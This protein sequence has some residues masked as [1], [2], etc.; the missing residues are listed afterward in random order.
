MSEVE[1]EV[2]GKK[3]VVRTDLRYTETEEWAKKEKDNRVREGITDYAQ[4]ELRDIVG[5]ELPEVGTEVK[6]GDSIGS[7]ESVKAVSD[8]YAAV[9]GRIV[10]VNERL[11]EEPELLNK[12]PYGDGWIVIIEMSDPNEYEQLLTPEAYIEKHK[13]SK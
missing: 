11:L 4:K 2:E 1:F 9:S 12:D 7:I 6:K 10:E 8:L 13:E 5:I 3:Y